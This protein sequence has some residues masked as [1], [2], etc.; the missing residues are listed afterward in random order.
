VLSDFKKTH[1][2]YPELNKNKPPDKTGSKSLFMARLS[3]ATMRLFVLRNF[4]P[5]LTKS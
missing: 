4:R 2:R 1:G 3:I 5:S